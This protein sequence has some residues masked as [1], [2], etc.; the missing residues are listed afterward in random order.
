MNGT[1][2]LLQH[3]LQGGVLGK[4]D[5][6][7]AGLHTDVAG[8]WGTCCA[9]WRGN[10]HGVRWHMGCVRAPI[11]ARAG[12][13]DALLVAGKLDEL[14]QFLLGE[15]LQSPPEKLDVLVCLHQSHLVH[16]VGLQ[17]LQVDIWEATG[18]QFHLQ[19]AEGGKQ[20]QGDDGAQAS[21]N[22][23]HALHVL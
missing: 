18:T 8:V 17:E 4:L 13:G 6:E 22:S 11:L 9:I 1:A 15:H 16:G 19:W 7:H 2:Q 14:A 5:H 10:L 23:C 21:T 20:L 3:D 12:E